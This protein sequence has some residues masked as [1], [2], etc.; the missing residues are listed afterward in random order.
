MATTAANPVAPT[1]LGATTLC[2]AFQVTAAERPD[3]IALRTPG[4]GVAISYGEY[5][6]RVRHIAGGLASLGVGRGDTVALMLVNRPEFNVVD[7]AAL[8]LGAVP[9]SIYNTSAPEQIQYLLSNAGA[10]VV[11]TEPAFLPRVRAAIRRGGVA[12]ERIVIVDGAGEEAIPLGELEQRTAAGFDF[13]ATWRA[14]MPEDL[15]TL[16]YTS[17]TT[18]PP[19]GVQIT[20]ANMIAEWRALHAAAPPPAH[21]RRISFLPP[22][23]PPRPW[24]GHH[25]A[26][27][28]RHQGT[29]C[30][31]PRPRAEPLRRHGARTR[32]HVLRRPAPGDG[33]RPRGAADHVRRG[34]ADLGEDEGRARGG[35]RGRAGRAAAGRRTLGARRGAPPRA[36]R[37][38]GR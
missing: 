36:R 16:I 25:R 5:A 17:G 31:D 9:F 34:A 1:A 3:Q 4:D 35:H 11:V 30:A 8:H 10:R 27:V 24:S 20:H 12:V 15:L 29:C 21:R 7:T 37:A 13:E 26:P 18:G 23:P 19:K 32:G 22:A 14:V 38:G 28:H 33:A 2:E 6:E